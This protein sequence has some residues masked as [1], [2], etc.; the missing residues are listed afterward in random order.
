MCVC[1]W[2]GHI[3]YEQA[4]KAAQLLLLISIKKTG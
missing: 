2:G 1:V 4:L 3:L